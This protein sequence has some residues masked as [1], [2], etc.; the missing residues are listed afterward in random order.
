[1][2]MDSE[3]QPFSEPKQLEME[4]EWCFLGASAY[5]HRRYLK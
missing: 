4:E 2:D 1:M 5:Y 3:K